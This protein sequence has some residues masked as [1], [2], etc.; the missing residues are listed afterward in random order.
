MRSLSPA[1]GSWLWAANQSSHNST[2]NPFLHLSIVLPWP[3][4]LPV[5][6]PT[7]ESY[8]HSLQ[9]L[10]HTLQPPC[11]NLTI[12]LL[13]DVPL[14]N[15]TW[16]SAPQP[17]PALVS[18]RWVTQ[19]TY[20]TFPSV[21][22]GTRYCIFTFNTSPNCQGHQAAS[23][24]EHCKIH[25]HSECF[26]LVLYSPNAFSQLHPSSGFYLLLPIICQKGMNF[27]Q[28]VT[29]PNLELSLLF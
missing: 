15:C 3:S 19:V 22:P 1:I 17:A 28:W 13:P 20:P 5:N 10:T 7:Q 23:P 4:N 9:F 6:S 21:A 2:K 29:L 18:C 12:W 26:F 11:L 24:W 14:P 25:F 16:L 27:Y 8:T